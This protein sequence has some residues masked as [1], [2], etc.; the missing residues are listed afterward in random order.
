MRREQ[1]EVEM[2]D[3]ATWICRFIAPDAHALIVAA[4]ARSV[5]LRRYLAAER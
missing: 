4:R 2:S 5:R 1:Q 3:F